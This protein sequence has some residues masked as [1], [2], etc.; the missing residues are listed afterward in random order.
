LTYCRN[1]VAP[2]DPCLILLSAEP[3]KNLAHICRFM[4]VAAARYLFCHKRAAS[5]DNNTSCDAAMFSGRDGQD[6][7][8]DSEKA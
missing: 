4:L 7:G 2:I 8:R 3:G 5:A 1:H 6:G